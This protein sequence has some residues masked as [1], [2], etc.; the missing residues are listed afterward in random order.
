MKFLSGLLVN[1]LLLGGIGLVLFLVFPDL[2]RQIFQL[3]GMIF[4][5]ALIILVIFVAALPRKQ[6][7]R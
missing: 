2:M 4:G 5:P 6:R 7:R 1:L 3:Y